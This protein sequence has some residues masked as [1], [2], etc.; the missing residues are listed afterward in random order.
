VPAISPPGSD[1]G[2]IGQ[3]LSPGP[4]HLPVQRF[5]SRSS[6]RPSRLHGETERAS[7]GG[8]SPLTVAAPRR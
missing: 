5:V 8:H 2:T 6:S 3:Y 1:I 4:K 7:C